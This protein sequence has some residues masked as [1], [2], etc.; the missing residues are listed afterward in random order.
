MDEI[1]D[2]CSNSYCFLDG[3]YMPSNFLDYSFDQIHFHFEFVVARCF[4]Y[5]YC[6]LLL[7]LALEDFLRISMFLYVWNEM[8]R[9][10]P[11][12]PLIHLYSDN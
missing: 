9:R 1:R 4:D 5:Y 3:S 8:L 11:L 6:N 7:F 12:N 2:Y 10:Y